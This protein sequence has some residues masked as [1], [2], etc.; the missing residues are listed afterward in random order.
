MTKSSDPVVIVGGGPVGI[1][2]ALELA[3]HGVRTVI[4]GPESG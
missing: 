3:R 4:L 1:G 2:T